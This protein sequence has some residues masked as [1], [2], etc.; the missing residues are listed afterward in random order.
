MSEG[1]PESIVGVDGDL[2]FASAPGL[3]LQIATAFALLP[4]VL[5]LDLAR[6]SF[7]D[8]AGLSLLIK[9]RRDGLDQDTRLRLRNTPRHV[10]RLLSICGIDQ[11]F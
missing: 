4:V 8:S 9:A 3:Q 6:C 2:D 1:T 7:I 5:V 11:L 10:E